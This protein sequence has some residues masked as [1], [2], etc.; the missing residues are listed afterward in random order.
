MIT[1]ETLKG[2]V[3]MDHKDNKLKFRRPKN[4]SSLLVA[5]FNTFVFLSQL[6]NDK[7]GKNIT[8][9]HA[10]IEEN[11]ISS[12]PFSFTI[13]ND[14][15][16]MIMVTEDQIILTERENN[17]LKQINLTTHEQHCFHHKFTAIHSDDIKL[18]IFSETGLLCVE[19]KVKNA[20]LLKLTY[21]C[22]PLV[23]GEHPFAYY[24]SKK[25]EFIYD[26]MKVVKANN[27]SMIVWF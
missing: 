2:N 21:Y 15:P 18:H 12:Y 26:Y 8:L 22:L 7:D 1:K 9:V 3:N 24:E 19:E 27:H 20:N 13:K 23:L 17:I 5:K 25:T 11:I 6:I 14:F 4:R 16:I 10:D